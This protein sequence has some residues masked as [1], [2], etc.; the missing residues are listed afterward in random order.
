MED[1]DLKSVVQQI[2]KKKRKDTM[3]RVII[4]LTG[5]LL[6]LVFI[7]LGLNYYS[8]S[9]KTV[10]EPD[11]KVAT[12]LQ[13]PPAPPQE[14]PIQP[15]QEQQPIQSSQITEQK[16]EQKLI[17]PP[18]VEEQ[19]Q[20]SQPI[21]KTEQKQKSSTIQPEKKET[22]NAQI[23][24]KEKTKT[25]E[26]AE[27]NIAVVFSIQ[28]GAFSTKEKAEIE[29]SKYT[30]AYIIEEGGLHK[31]LIGKFKSEKEARDYQREHS[32]KGFIKKVGS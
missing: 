16:Q 13:K 18:Q 10:S 32:I 29:K 27:K 30:N 21:Q 14:T 26:K 17:Q 11:I 7:A 1:R 6:T 23:K 5:L 12:E 25:E 3:E 20:K 22:S 24:Q 4:F 31:V 19:K 8:K 2:K 9:E 15:V 28:V